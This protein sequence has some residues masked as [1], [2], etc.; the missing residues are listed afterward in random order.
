MAISRPTKNVKSITDTSTSGIVNYPF[1]VPESTNSIVVRVYAGT[2]TG[3][4]PTCDVYVQTTEDGGTNWR[5]CGRFTQITA[6]GT[7]EAA[8]FMP[9]SAISSI[10]GQGDVTAYISSVQASMLAA[11]RQSGLPLMGKYN[12]ISIK[13]GGTIGVNGGVQVDVFRTGHDMGA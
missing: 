13:Y 11:S 6:S 9:V 12:R 3:T 5:D 1:F 7:I 8:Q 10:G 2:F 4:S